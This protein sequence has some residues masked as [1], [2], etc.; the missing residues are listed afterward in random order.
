MAPDG[1]RL[2][3]PRWVATHP[4]FLRGLVVLVCGFGLAVAVNA[5]WARAIDMEAYHLAGRAALAHEPLY[6]QPMVGGLSFVYSPWA[7]LLFTPLALLPL[8]G[9]QAVMVAVNCAALIFAAWRSWQSVGLTDRRALPVLAVLVASASLWFQSVHATVYV[10]QINLVLLALVVGDLLRDDRRRS[11]GLGVGIA[12]GVKLTPM[13]FVPYLFVTRRP[14]AAAVAVGSFLGTVVVGCAVLPADSVKFWL[15][16]TFA[17]ST[18]ISPDA[19]APRNVSVRGLLIRLFGDTSTT[20]AWWFGLAALLAAGTIA[21]GRRA[22]RDGEELLAV[23]L[24]GLCSAAVSPWAW[25]NHWV[26][27]VPLAVFVANQALRATTRD[28]VLIWTP[29]ATLAVMTFSRLLSLAAPPTPAPGVRGPPLRVPVAWLFGNIYVLI[30]LGTL[31]TTALYLRQ[32]AA[33][34][35]EVNGE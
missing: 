11:K 4:L 12:A 27:L 24:C 3:L 29:V 28:R 26:W 21:L 33:G 22:H 32:S 25:D 20:E 17:D 23:T 18:R 30:F 31:V 7:A 6:D 19:G 14:R 35:G 34:Q 13:L 5:L 1:T 9:A 2:R 15:T 8:A 16:G 10:G